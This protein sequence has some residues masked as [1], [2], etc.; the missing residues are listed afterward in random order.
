[1]YVYRFSWKP[2]VLDGL[3]QAAHIAGMGGSA[4]RGNVPGQGSSQRLG[5]PERATRISEMSPSRSV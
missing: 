2:P 5:C 4:L 3:V 1:M